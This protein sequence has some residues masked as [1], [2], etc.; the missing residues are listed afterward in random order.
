MLGKHLK[1]RNNR[2]AVLGF[3]TVSLFSRTSISEGHTTRWKRWDSFSCLAKPYVMHDDF[4][5]AKVL[6]SCY[7]NRANPVL[8]RKG[9]YC[10]EKAKI[11]D[12]AFGDCFDFYRRRLSL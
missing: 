10:Y 4:C 2:T 11:G 7:N 12:R 1:F 9:W 6:L 5:L 8:E 3:V